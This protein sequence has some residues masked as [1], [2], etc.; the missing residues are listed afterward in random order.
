MRRSFWNGLLTGSLIGAAMAWFI[1]PQRRPG[2][3][4]RIVGR[5]ANWPGRARR[6]LRR[7]REGVSEIMDR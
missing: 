4:R 1:R 6:V 2:T 7:M 3:V 5:S